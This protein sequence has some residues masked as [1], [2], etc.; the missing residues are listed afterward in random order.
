L[1]PKSISRNRF[2]RSVHFILTI[3]L[4]LINNAGVGVRPNLVI[5]GQKNKELENRKKIIFRPLIDPEL[6]RTIGIVT[7]FGTTLSP[8]ADQLLSFLKKEIIEF[9]KETA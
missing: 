6:T 2:R 5:R 1:F 7:K 3:S 8:M 9:G 4:P